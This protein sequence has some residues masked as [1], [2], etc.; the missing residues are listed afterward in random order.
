M[1]WPAAEWEKVFIKHIS[2]REFVSRL[3]EEKGKNLQVSNIKNPLKFTDT[4][5]DVSLEHM[6]EWA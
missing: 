3:L 1:K 4:S 5:K 6:Y 2:N